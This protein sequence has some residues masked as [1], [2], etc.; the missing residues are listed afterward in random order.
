VPAAAVADLAG[1]SGGEIEVVVDEVFEMDRGD[2]RVG[3][4]RHEGGFAFVVFVL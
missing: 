1:E 4:E 3:E 2:V